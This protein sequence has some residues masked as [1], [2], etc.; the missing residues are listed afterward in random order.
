M[1][2]FNSS[3]ELEALN[4]I[5]VLLFQSLFWVALSLW[6]Y[7]HFDSARGA[8]PHCQSCPCAGK[9]KAK[10]QE[11]LSD[12]SWWGALSGAHQIQKLR[13]EASSIASDLNANQALLFHGCVFMSAWPLLQLTN[14][15]PVSATFSKEG[16]F[17]QV[18]KHTTDFVTIG[19]WVKEKE[20]I[21]AFTERNPPEHVPGQ[22]AG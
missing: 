16:S 21:P 9:V 14:H 6:W 5:P 15:Q 19:S 13:P 3:V 8:V 20:L 1:V 7:S 10:R 17:S 11:V 22:M 2:L 12:P 18:L 4:S